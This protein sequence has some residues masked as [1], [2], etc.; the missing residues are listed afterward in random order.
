MYANRPGL[1]WF[2]GG[3]K[4]VALP[5]AEISSVEAL[6]QCRDYKRP[7]EW[8]WEKNFG[9]KYQSSNAVRQESRVVCSSARVRSTSGKIAYSASQKSAAPRSAAQEYRQ[10]CLR[11]E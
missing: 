10:G 3:A 6:I 4:R 7:Q 9:A 1:L 5:T 2:S 11:T 8:V